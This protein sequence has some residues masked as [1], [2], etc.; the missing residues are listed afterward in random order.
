MKHV[1]KF[2]RIRAE[3]PAKPVD[4]S[5]NSTDFCI[6]WNF[7]VHHVSQLRFGRFF[8]I[9]KKSTGSL[10]SDFYPPA[11]F[12]NPGAHPWLLHTYLV[13]P[14]SSSNRRPQAFP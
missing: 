6:F 11:E 12:V 8:R 5:A 9:F 7:S 1:T 13:Q 14:F 2:V 10:G 3:L 4:N